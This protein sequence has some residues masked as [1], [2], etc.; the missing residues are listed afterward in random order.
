MSPRS[1]AFTSRPQ[2]ALVPAPIATRSPD[3]DGV[4]TVSAS[5]PLEYSEPRVRPTLLELAIL[6]GTATWVVLLLL[7]RWPALWYPQFN[8]NSTI[9]SAFFTY[10]GQVVRDGVG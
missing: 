10:A 2:P 9:D 6:L 8:S 5:A 1:N 4:P 3:A 7:M